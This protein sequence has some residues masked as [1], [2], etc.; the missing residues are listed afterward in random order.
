M[1]DLTKTGKKNIATLGDRFKAILDDL[2]EYN[3]VFA[4]AQDFDFWP[5]GREFKDARISANLCVI[6]TFRCSQVSV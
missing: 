2:K 1:G 3:Q 6:E 5:V 4:I